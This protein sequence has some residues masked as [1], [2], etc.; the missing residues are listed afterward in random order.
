[1]VGVI[2]T[3]R[4]CKSLSSYPSMQDVVTRGGKLLGLYKRPGKRVI[5]NDSGHMMVGPA[6]IEYTLQQNTAGDIISSAHT[7][8]SACVKQPYRGL[9]VSQ[10]ALVLPLACSFES[11]LINLACSRHM[12]DGAHCPNGILWPA[13]LVAIF[14]ALIL[15]DAWSVAQ[16]TRLQPAWDPI[17]DKKLSHHSLQLSH[18]TLQLSH[19]TLPLS[20]HTLLACRS[21]CVSPPASQLPSRHPVGHSCAI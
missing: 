13:C 18:H 5:V 4:C 17:C 14:N 15:A 11:Y 6:M 3:L 8:A 12:D 9:V 7:F 2:T 10:A 21:E 16:V 20:H 19:H 1:M